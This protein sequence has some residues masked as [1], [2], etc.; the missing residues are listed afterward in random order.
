MKALSKITIVG[1]T[2]AVAI[3]FSALINPALAQRDKQGPDPNRQERHLQLLKDRLDLTDGQVNEIK[4]IMAQARNEAEKARED[5]K[6]DR[7]AAM[8]DRKAR[9]EANDEKIKSV[10]NDNQKKEYETVKDELRQRR[11]SR[12]G[13]RGK[14]DGSGKRGD[15]RGN[16]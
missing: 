16:R 12:D 4:A 9:R 2:V 6:G 11:E 3:M 5:R 13:E 7:E 8:K 15:R 14:R 10:L 1:L